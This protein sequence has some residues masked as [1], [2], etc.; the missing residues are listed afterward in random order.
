[1]PTTTTSTIGSGGTYS[2]IALWFAACPANLVSSDAIWR[3]EL[4]NQ[5]FSSA[6]N[7]LLIAGITTDSTRYIELTTEAGAS[8]RDNGSVQSNALRFN[9]SNGAS[10]TVTG[11]YESAIG[12]NSG[13]GFTRFSKL[14]IAGT[15][16]SA[17]AAIAASDTCIIDFC[18]LEGKASQ[19][20]AQMNGNGTNIM[21]NSLV[22]Q[23]AAS[24][25]RVV[26]SSITMQM[27][28]CTVVTPS[29]VAASTDALR[30]QYGTSAVI[31]NCAFFGSTNVAIQ[32][33]G[34]RPPAGTTFTTC[35]T[36]VGS[37]PTGCTQITY[38]TST[39]SG[40]ENISDATRD[41]R[42]KSGSAMLDVGTTD[43]TNAANDIAGTARPSGSAYDIGCWE[44]VVGGGAAATLVTRKL[45]LGVG[46]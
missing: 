4:K 34:S 6:N 30:V 35:R 2:T 10:I 40:F 24:A 20:V 46:A 42:I 5:A 38:N 44:L 14:Q 37:P 7:L 8:F 26:D 23:R 19:G 29:D 32:Q 43:S 16:S 18:I 45:L 3:G 28:N 25:T 13:T 21:R 22:V 27:T 36:D 33:G 31:K 41:Y 9:S 17:C 1:M 12:I 39:G 11:G 15:G